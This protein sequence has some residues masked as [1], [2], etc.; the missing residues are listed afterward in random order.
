MKNTAEFLH[1][2]VPRLEIES[3]KTADYGSGRIP[4]VYFYHTEDVPGSQGMSTAGMA[5]DSSVLG[6]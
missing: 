5:I 6:Q 4:T 2:K 1:I 3:A